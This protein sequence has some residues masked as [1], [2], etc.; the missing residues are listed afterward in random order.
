MFRKRETLQP[1]E[2][3]KT[4]AQEA[5]QYSDETLSLV[6]DIDNSLADSKNLLSGLDQLAKAQVLT[7]WRERE[8][9]EAPKQIG[10]LNLEKDDADLFEKGGRWLGARNLI[11]GVKHTLK[12]KEGVV[13]TRKLKEEVKEQK[14]DLNKAELKKLKKFGLDPKKINPED[15]KITFIE[16]EKGKSAEKVVLRRKTEE[17]M[18][19]TADEIMERRL[20]ELETGA[21][22]KLIKN[23]ESFDGFMRDR[24]K[25]ED[26]LPPESL[27]KLEREETDRREIIERQQRDLNSELA[28]FGEPLLEKQQNLDWALADFSILLNQTA[29]QEKYYQDEIAS[30]QKTITGV[31][32]SEEL[33]KVFRR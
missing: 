24:K 4:Q 27:E 17:E 16:G 7:D 28:V 8:E 18:I 21:G 14:Y 22:A 15:F 3:S 10:K 26:I 29:V 9:I 25:Y 6:Q 32:S 2:K 19:K 20:K 5:P 23:K 1:A 12:G 11:Y 31:K 30:L 13:D 33:S